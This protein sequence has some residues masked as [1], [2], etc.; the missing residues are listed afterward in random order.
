MFAI[1]SG[2]FASIIQYLQRPMLGWGLGGPL[3]VG[4]MELLLGHLLPYSLLTASW[5]QG[6]LG[7][8]GC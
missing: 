5:Q 4:A 8:R 2:Q 7:F 3:Q 1:I 6:F